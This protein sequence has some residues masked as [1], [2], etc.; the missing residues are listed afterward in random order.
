M[1]LVPLL[2][3]IVLRQMKKQR[4]PGRAATTTGNDSGSSKEAQGSARTL[5]KKLQAGLTVSA[6]GRRMATN[7]RESQWRAVTVQLKILVTFMQVLSQLHTVYAIPYPASF[8]RFL[9]RMAFFNLDLVDVLRVG[10][11]TS[12]NYYDRLLA[13]TLLPLLLSAVLFA[14]SCVARF[15]VAPE[16][17][18]GVANTCIK[19]FLL[20]TFTA[21]PGVSTTVLRAFPCHDFDDGSSLLKADYSIDCN[22][23]SRPGYVTYALLMTAV[24]PVGITMLYAVLLWKQRQT[25][26]PEKRVWKALCGVKL[27]P[28]VAA[29]LAD[30]KALLDTREAMLGDKSVNKH[31]LLRSTQFLFKEYEPRYWWFEIFECV[32]RIMLTGGTIFFLE[33]SA[34]QV[35]AGV[36]VSM[37]SI[38]VYAH[39]QPYIRDEDDTLAMA[40]QWGIFFTLFGGLLLKTKVPSGDGYDEG[41]GFM[42]VLVNVAVFAGAVF[43][44]LYLMCQPKQ[45]SQSRE[46]TATG[47]HGLATASSAPKNTFVNPMQTAAA[48]GDTAVVIGAQASTTTQDD[49]SD[50]NP[51]YRL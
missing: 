49:T 15:L 40:A 21:F 51:A 32:R 34:T 6:H 7:T 35:A 25:V 43:A 13:A 3:Y 44:F 36:L 17:A 31:S 29:S 1:L 19:L 18:Q 4:T 9:Q 24:Y 5:G 14:T 42:L 12:I 27:I 20:L 38:Q 41:L 23:P 8:V 39:T 2:G 45:G 48:G 16:K 50:G 28:P 47:E 33:G 37:V 26:C 30:G 11:M 10:C 22:A 46:E